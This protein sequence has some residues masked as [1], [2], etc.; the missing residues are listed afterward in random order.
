MKTQTRFMIPALVVMVIVI[1]GPLVW[2]IGSSFCDWNWAEPNGM[3]N[4][5]FSGIKNYI[6]MFQD[7]LFRNSILNTFLFSF[8][9]L[10]IE[11]MLGMACALL[12]NSIHNGVLLYRTAL[13]FPLM[14]SDIVVALM[15]KMLLNPSQGVL[16]RMLMAVGMVNPINWV[17]DASLVIPSLAF[18][19]AW[20]QSGNLTLI[21]LAGLQSIP[22]SL[23]DMSMVDGASSF[24]RFRYIVFPYTQPFI[25][26]AIVLRLID[27]MRVFTLPWAITGGGPGRASE[28]TQVFIY[29][30]GMGKYMR[31]GYSNALAVTFA[32]IVVLVIAFIQRC[33]KAEE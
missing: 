23:I 22:Q 33:W 29:T 32:L 12:L 1:L 27:L 25:K 28:M 3:D 13:M 11:F 30:Q 2:G 17:G 26:T 10:I 4:I 14:L 15:F 16:N 19:D 7:P 18:V 21:I 9:A 24:A 6:E 5:R 31:M 8:I 20:W